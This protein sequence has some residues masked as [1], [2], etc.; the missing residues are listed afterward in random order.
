MKD[1]NQHLKS[2][3][4]YAL[5]E[6]GE[7]STTNNLQDG[8]IMLIDIGRHRHTPVS[9]YST[10]HDAIDFMGEKWLKSN[11]PYE[12]EY[13]VIDDEW[14]VHQSVKASEDY[15]GAVSKGEFGGIMCM[16]NRCYYNKKGE[17]KFVK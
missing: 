11:V 2:T 13:L 9:N 4:I 3:N 8:W 15:F 7:F 5:Y 6:G 10:S 16:T 1:I 12:G 17:F 14:N